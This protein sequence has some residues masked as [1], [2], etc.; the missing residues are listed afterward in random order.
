MRQ[1]RLA[2]LG[3]PL[4]LASA[5]VRKHVCPPRFAGGLLR[6]RPRS[7][8]DCITRLHHGCHQPHD[9]GQGRIEQDE[10]RPHDL[11]VWRCYYRPRVSPMSRR[12]HHEA[13]NANKRLDWCRA[14]DNCSIHKMPRFWALSPMVLPAWGWKM[15]GTTPPTLSVLSD[16]R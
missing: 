14:P 8:L 9:V 10:I 12:R 11:F 7:T 13:R 5:W 15:L 16:G 1:Q 2:Y 4:S 3:A 6:V